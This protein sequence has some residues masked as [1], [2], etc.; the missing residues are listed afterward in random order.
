[1][2]DIVISEV[3]CFVQNYIHTTPKEDL[4]KSVATFSVESLELARKLLVKTNVFPA[5]II[6]ILTPSRK[7]SSKR[8]ACVALATDITEALLAA[9]HPIETQFV[10]KNLADLPPPPGEVDVW[11][12]NQRLKALERDFYT[13][14]L[15]RNTTV[16]IH[17]SES[18]STPKE[19]LQPGKE[20]VLLP[21]ESD[22]Q[23]FTTV[24]NKKKLARKNREAS[25]SSSVS[26]E[27]GAAQTSTA[28]TTQ[29]Q[30]PR[31]QV[32]VGSKTENTSQLSAGPTKLFVS[33]ISTTVSSEQLIEYIKSN[34]VSPIN[35]EEFNN[36]DPARAKRFIVSIKSTDRATLLHSEFWPV[37]VRCNSYYESRKLQQWTGGKALS[38]RQQTDEHSVFQ[39]PGNK[40]QN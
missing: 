27:A 13:D 12:I 6:Q 16:Q 2:S 29:P 3:L 24:V 34:G 9:Q 7:D 39:L 40:K 21:K 10:A 15:D 25:T 17:T 30:R 5:E 33:N 28:N 22:E 26:A 23:S 36:S 32:I 1:M 38:G 8:L 18:V 11:S 14:R 20:T 19:I 31:R 35:A 4:V 37:A